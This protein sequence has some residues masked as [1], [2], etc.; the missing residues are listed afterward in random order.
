[1]RVV[2]IKAELTWR[3]KHCHGGKADLVKLL[4]DA[5]ARTVD[6]SNRNIADDESGRGE[7]GGVETTAA[8]RA[9]RRLR[10]A[11]TARKALLGCLEGVKK[12]LEEYSAHQLRTVRHN[13]Y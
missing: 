9:S 6:D 1:M 8:V 7:Y 5:R 13:A 4:I 3:G 10:G 11:A 2:G 12:N